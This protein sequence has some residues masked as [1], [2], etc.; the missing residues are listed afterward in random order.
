SGA[1]F[2]LLLGLRR[3]LLLA[4]EAQELLEGLEQPLLVHGFVQDLIDPAL[5]H[6]EAE[7]PHVAIEGGAEEDREF[8]PTE[9]LAHLPRDL[10]AAQPGQESVQDHEAKG[11]GGEEA[12]RF[13]AGSDVRAGQPESRRHPAR[14]FMKT[15]VV[16]DDEDS[17]FVPTLHE[18]LPAHPPSLHQGRGEEPAKWNARRLGR[19]ARSEEHTSE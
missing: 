17:S 8:L 1:E 6:Q 12:E 10:L 16:V 15:T 7:A 11:L 14:E 9:A 3:L 4:L 2:R 18:N 5:V 19:G 13:L